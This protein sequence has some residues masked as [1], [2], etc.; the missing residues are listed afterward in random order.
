[1][2]GSGFEQK[3]GQSLASSSSASVASAGLG[4]PRRATLFDPPDGD[5][6]IRTLAGL[7][8]IDL[9][10]A[11]GSTAARSEEQV[12]A[13][14]RRY[15]AIKT[16]SGIA[17]V[18]VSIVLATLLA[19][20]AISLP[21]PDWNLPDLPRPDLPDLP[22]PDWSLPGWLR[23]ILNHAGYV[24]PI[25]VALVLARAEIRRRKKQDELRSRRSGRDVT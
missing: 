22:L 5:A 12:R 18:L 14:P 11:A 8:G 10:P 19:R 21:L 6:D 1:M 9:E 15:A 2:T 20:W 16:T 7:G 17:T 25:I 13:H 4:R 24:V 3:I 23:S